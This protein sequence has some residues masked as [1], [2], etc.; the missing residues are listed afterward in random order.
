MADVLTFP[1]GCVS[2][3]FTLN[4]HGKEFLNRLSS[5]SFL[6]QRLWPL[7]LQVLLWMLR[8]W[9]SHCHNRRP[10]Y[11]FLQILWANRTSVNSYHQSLWH[12]MLK[13][14]EQLGLFYPIFHADQISVWNLDFGL[15][16]GTMPLSKNTA[17]VKKKWAIT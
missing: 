13:L 11:L 16:C 9:I 4:V 10:V 3:C 7:L 2:S 6:L 5:L 1:N 8:E 12:M 15:C 17:W 14:G